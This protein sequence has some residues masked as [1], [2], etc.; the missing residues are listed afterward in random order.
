MYGIMRFEKLKSK[1]ELAGAT[2]HVGRKRPTPNADPERAKYNK[3]LHGSVDPVQAVED[4]YEATGAT[5]RK[6]GVLAFEFI[7]T[8]SP[9]FFREH[10]EYGQ[11]DVELTEALGKKAIA[12]L[13][14]EF[15][16]ENVVNVTMHLDE[17]TPHIHAYVTPLKRNKKGKWAQAAKQ[18]T[19]SKK[20]CSEMQDRFA[21]AVSE[22]GL[23]RGIKGSKAKHTKVKE[24]YAAMEAEV[25]NVPSVTVQAPPG[26]SVLTET[27]R[28]EY[29]KE[30]TQR[31]QKKIAPVVA[32]LRDQA[33]S[34]ELSRK[35]ELE[36]KKTA[37][38]YQ[39]EASILED[40]PMQ[41]V[42]C[43]FGY[44]EG[45][46]H[47]QTGKQVGLLGKYFFDDQ[48][49]RR[50]HGSIELAMHLLDCGPD[51][52]LACLGRR[53]GQDMACRALVCRTRHYAMQTVRQ[54]M[55]EHPLQRGKEDPEKGQTTSQGPDA[56]PE[57]EPGASEEPDFSGPGFSPG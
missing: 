30:E 23:R 43:A 5:K 8:A 38:K 9:E 40:I 17:A 27:K 34:A 29:A 10:N 55:K 3:T 50:G 18:W 35:K 7:V 6:N 22:L 52:A 37:E 2:A 14:E 56:R 48:S 16:E 11:H 31:I 24:Y 4:R 53:F 39:Q 19:G 25:E 57:I 20:L 26:W 32:R 42:L 13:K 36:Y 46:C 47:E 54:A 45:V 21:E 33:K 41:D 1:N 28:Q 49:D 51:K 12:W 15:G 44:Q